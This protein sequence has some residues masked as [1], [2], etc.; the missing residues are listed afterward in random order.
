MAQRL[1]LGYKQPLRCLIG[2][3]LVQASPRAQASDNARFKLRY[4]IYELVFAFSPDT[5]WIRRSGWRRFCLADQN[6]M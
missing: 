1:Q 5:K 6:R 4:V 3:P 2:C